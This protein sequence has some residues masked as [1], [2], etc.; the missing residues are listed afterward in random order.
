MADT[1]Y[2]CPTGIN[3]LDVLTSGGLPRACGL[4]LKGPSHSGKSILSMQ[5]LYTA[6]KRGEGCLYI[7]YG[8]PY[9][10][11]LE[12]FNSFGWDLEPFLNRGN[13]K[14]LDNATRIYGLDSSLKN[15]TESVR[16]GIVITNPK[17]Q[18]EYLEQQIRVMEDVEA[19]SDRIG[20]NVIDSI[21]Y[22]VRFLREVQWSSNEIT[23]YF[24]KIRIRIGG[25]FPVIGIHISTPISGE[26]SIS[27]ILDD[28]EK[29]TIEIKLED[30][31]SS[32][33]KRFLRIVGLPL[34]HHD[35]KWHEFRIT[36]NGIE[37]M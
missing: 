23:N 17:D 28:V 25:R 1:S 35:R 2:R 7:S 9:S 19:N 16:K 32:E 33:M 29:G 15:L 37:L 24:Q 20:I 12:T 8:E 3:K 27:Q 4:H 26:E 18:D 34:T 36:H 6:L 21:N 22:R 5:M 13:M 11:I 10:D 14:I 30:D 31:D